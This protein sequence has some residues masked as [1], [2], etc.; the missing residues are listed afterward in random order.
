[1]QSLTHDVKCADGDGWDMYL[2]HRPGNQSRR[3][4]SSQQGLENVQIRHMV[5]QS[6]QNGRHL[7]VLLDV[8]GCCIQE[9]L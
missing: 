4:L 1:M 9:R 2:A 7:P 5:H 6:S 8:R 3:S